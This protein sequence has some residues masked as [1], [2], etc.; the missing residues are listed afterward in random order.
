MYPLKNN[1]NKQMR[2]I[3]TPYIYILFFLLKFSTI[4]SQNFQIS[5]TTI[6][7]ENNKIIKEIPYIK[8]HNSKMSILNEINEINRELEKIGFLNATLDKFDLIDSTFNAKYILGEQTKKIKIFYN[9]D[10]ISNLFL[11]KKELHQISTSLTDTY[12]EIPFNEISN[13][14]QFIADTY[15]KNGNSFTQVSLKNI[16]LENEIALADLYIIDTKARTIDK[17]IIKGYKKFPKNFIVND[18]NLKLKSVFN[19]DKLETASTA[20][21][22]LPFV[23]EQKTPEVL[24]TKD[25]TFIYLYLKKKRSNKFDGVI[26]FSTKEENNSLEFNG[27][28]DLLF[29][30]IFNSGESIALFWKNNGNESQRFFISA[31]TPYIFNLPI[32]PK[33]TFE[34]F[35]Q[36]STFN[37]IIANFH[38]S[39]LINNKSKIAAAFNTESSTNLLKNNNTNLNIQSFKNI[40]YGGAYNFIILNN[41]IL[42]TEKFNLNV[43]SFFGN[44]KTDNEKTSQSK[45]TLFS[46]F[47]WPLNSKNY[48]FIQ[49]QSAILNS[50]DYFDNELFRIGGV[51]SIRGF[52]EESIFTT[53]YSILNIEYRFRPSLSSYF[54]TITDFA[55]IENQILSTSAKIYSLGLGYTFLTKIGLLN[56]SYAIGKFNDNPFNFNDSKLHIK[57]VSFF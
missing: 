46:N 52:N 10:G 41:D 8:F 57:I 48:L 6:K 56:L 21:K 5:V 38:L 2:V 17:I 51:N 22:S 55:Y 16:H 36:D 44:R 19:N 23:E 4:Y 3:F 32:T 11:S 40:F 13:S 18:L 29:N 27:Y 39:Y 37:N 15:E 50:D 9:R 24:F 1:K 53:G 33:A 54:Y 43:S 49:N 25:S 35:R 30:N 7:S 47:L 45:F 28:L 34:L 31:E 26:G 12:F 20:L 42:F 14:L